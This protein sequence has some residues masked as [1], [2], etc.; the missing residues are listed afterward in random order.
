METAA[1]LF[2]VFQVPSA[3]IFRVAPYFE[4]KFDRKANAH[5]ERNL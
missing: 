2:R 1:E 3:R 4:Q 5:D